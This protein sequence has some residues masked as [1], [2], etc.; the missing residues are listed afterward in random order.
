VL[1]GLLGGL[2]AMLAHGLIDNAIF[3]PELAYW[4]MFMLACLANASCVSVRADE[5]VDDMDMS[6]AVEGRDGVS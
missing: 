3:V 5:N 4:T 2:A 1:G 6:G